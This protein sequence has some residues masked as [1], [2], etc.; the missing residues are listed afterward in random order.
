MLFWRNHNCHVHSLL[1]AV[2]APAPGHGHPVCKKHH[3]DAHTIAA[4]AFVF[5]VGRRRADDVSPSENGARNEPITASMIAV[6][7][8]NQPADES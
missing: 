4:L 3:P 8:A 6:E 2:V 7:T 5:S 1:A